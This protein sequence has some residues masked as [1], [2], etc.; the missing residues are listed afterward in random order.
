M[1]TSHPLRIQAPPT[2]LFMV[3]SPI[4]LLPGKLAAK[5]L[6]PTHQQIGTR[7]GQ[8]VKKGVVCS[9]H[10]P[11]QLSFA[12]TSLAAANHTRSQFL[13]NQNKIRGPHAI[14]FSRLGHSDLLTND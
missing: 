13:G 6:G 2:G 10:G 4:S 7:T 9:T 11:A 14:F 8:C 5:P 12:R 3:Q 1:G